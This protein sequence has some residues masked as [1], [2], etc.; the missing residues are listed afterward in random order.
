MAIF[1]IHKTYNEMKV[2]YEQ[3]QQKINEFKMGVV[4]SCS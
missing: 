2:W 4:E 1:S 3:A